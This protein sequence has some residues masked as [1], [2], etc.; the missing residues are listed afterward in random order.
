MAHF[1]KLYAGIQQIPKQRV[2]AILFLLV[3]GLHLEVYPG[4]TQ[5]NEIEFITAAPVLP[6]NVNTAAYST[7]LHASGRKII[8]PLSFSKLDPSLSPEVYHQYFFK[9]DYTRLNRQQQE[10]PNAHWFY[11]LQTVSGFNAISFSSHS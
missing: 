6:K 8:S 11:A 3:L 10:M 7:G 1:T 2:W 5:P 9:V 4:L